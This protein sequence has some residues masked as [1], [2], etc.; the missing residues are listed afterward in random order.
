MKL[1]LTHNS[2]RIRIQRSELA[3]L[4]EAHRIRESVAFP[5][6]TAFHFEISIHEGAEIKAAFEA[7][8]L[9]IKLPD[10]IAQPWFDTQQ[11]GIETH[12]SLDGND[13][14]HLLLEKDFPCPDRPNEDRSETFWELADK[15]E[16]S[17]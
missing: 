7:N 10:S 13:Q 5:A 16:P 11:V 3:Q 17:C 15:P 1:R 12:L 9:T 14:L 4:Q 8:T 2:I 6:K